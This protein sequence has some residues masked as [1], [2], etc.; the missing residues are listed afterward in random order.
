MAGRL[1][2]P[3]IRHAHCGPG[4]P[5]AY[6]HRPFCL[7]S[8]TDAHSGPSQ[9]DAYRPSG[10]STLPMVS[11]SPSPQWASPTPTAL[12]VS[13]Q[14]TLT[15]G[16]VSLTPTATALPVSASPTPTVGPVSPTPSPTSD[17]T[18]YYEAL[19]CGPFSTL[20]LV[21]VLRLCHRLTGLGP[22]EGFDDMTRKSSAQQR[23]I[24]RANAIGYR[25]DGHWL[26]R[27]RRPNAVPEAAM[28]LRWRQPL[29]SPSAARRARRPSH[30]AAY[31]P[32]PA[33][34]PRRAASADRR[35]SPSLVGPDSQAGAAPGRGRCHRR[36]AHSIRAIC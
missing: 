4:Q 22:H 36:R 23:A 11:A 13:A 17:V 3:I 20:G 8:T 9:P 29:T 2:G 7:S 28:A 18:S 6:R 32:R 25:R 14:P 1:P 19:P 30:C 35:Q 31:W 21:V 16:Q 34:C 26:N 10:L 15:A 12:P 27:D 24:S 33:V 5:D